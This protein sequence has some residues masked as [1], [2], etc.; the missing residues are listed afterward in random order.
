MEM[1][2]VGRKNRLDCVVEAIIDELKKM[3]IEKSRKRVGVVLFGSEVTVVGDGSGKELK[4]PNGLFSSYEGLVGNAQTYLPL[5]SLSITDSYEQL[6]K[7]VK[8]TI[9]HG[10][11]ALGPAL[12]TSIELASHGA[13]GSRVIIC[14]DG[15]ANVGVG[16][17]DNNFYQKT[18]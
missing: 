10:S 17:N 7:T 12:V 13:P 1:E 2:V 14:T 18:A 5:F 16:S 8:D 4:V 11:T 9:C 15:E 6:K 3:K